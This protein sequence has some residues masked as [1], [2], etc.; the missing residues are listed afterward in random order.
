MALT[1]GRTVKCLFFSLV[2]LL[3]LCISFIGDLNVV[4]FGVMGGSIGVLCSVSCIVCSHIALV[5]F[6]FV[7]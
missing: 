7:F 2:V 1:L 3:L 5:F 4:Q 6:S